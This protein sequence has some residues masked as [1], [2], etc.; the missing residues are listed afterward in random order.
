MWPRPGPS[1]QDR[2]TPESEPTDLIRIALVTRRRS[3]R[4]RVEPPVQGSGVGERR[5]LGKPVQHGL[6]PFVGPILD[7][8][9][10]RI[11]VDDAV[12]H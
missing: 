11:V 9:A 10:V 1:N 5:F 3:N 12:I 8:F 2:L 4:N 6:H 7:G